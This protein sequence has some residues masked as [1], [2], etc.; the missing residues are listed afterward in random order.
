MPAIGSLVLYGTHGV[1]RV[2]GTKL[3]KVDRKMVEYYV[4]TP[5]EQATAC[6]YVPVNNQL[7]VS[8]MRPLL[9]Q[10]ALTALLKSEEVNVDCWIEEENRRKLTYREWIGRG[11]RVALL[12]IVRTLTR[13]KEQQLLSGKKFHV[14]DESFLKD[15][16]KLLVAEI[17]VVLDIPAEKA[18]EYLS[19]NIAE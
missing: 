17:S 5:V 7:A 16:L 4:L 14:S 15:A 8:K 3:Q 6:F 10:E 2:C 19:G 13:H 9:T 18:I 11:D 1:C 12:R